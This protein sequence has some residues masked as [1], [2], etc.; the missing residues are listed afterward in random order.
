[1]LS[2]EPADVSALTPGHFLVGKRMVSLP[3]TDVMNINLNCL[4]FRHLLNKFHKHIWRKWSTECIHT[5]YH[6]ALLS[7]FWPLKA[8]NQWR[9][10]RDNLQIEELSLHA[11]TIPSSAM[12]ACKSYY[13]SSQCRWRGTWRVTQGKTVSQTFTG[14]EF[15]LFLL[16]SKTP[17]E[18]NSLQGGRDVQYH[19]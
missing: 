18:A 1:M 12:A 9:I 13:N 8:R 17:I 15:K 7:N 19:R 14:P 10:H 4:N 16:P 3:E 11:Y 2:N 5:L 6:F